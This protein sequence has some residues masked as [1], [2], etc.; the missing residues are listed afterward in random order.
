MDA[1]GITIVRPLSVFGWDDAPHGHMEVLF[2]NVR[3]PASNML[4]G[5]EPHHRAHLLGRRQVRVRVGVAQDPPPG[6]GDALAVE[7]GLGGEVVEEQAPGDA[8]LGGDLVDREV[9]DRPV[10]EL[11]QT[12]AD[13]LAAPVLAGQPGP[14][15]RDRHAI[16]HC[17]TS[18]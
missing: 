10:D 1:K 8:R 16:E 2:E 17:S 11:R 6:R 12:D 3:V 18:L 15:G 7:V 9:V 4:L 14:A 5:E 13:Q